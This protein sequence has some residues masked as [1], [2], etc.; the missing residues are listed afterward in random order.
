MRYALLP[1]S[2]AA[3][4]GEKEAP[5]TR[6][7]W[8]PDCNPMA[9]AG[10]CLLPLPSRHWMVEDP[11]SP[12]GLRFDYRDDTF[13]SPDGPLPI[14]IS[15]FNSL[16]G[17]PPTAPILLNLGRDVHINAL[18]G[19]DEAE[20][21][22]SADAPLAL[23]HLDTGARVPLLTEM[24][25]NNRDLAG[26]AYT[27]RHALILRPLAPMQPGGRYAVLVSDDLRDSENQPFSSPPV[28]AA[29]RDNVLTDDDT[30][31]GMRPRYE[32]I[33][34]A[35][36]A[37]GYPRERLLLAWDLQVAS[38][39]QV[40]GPIL[41]MRELTLASAE[42][43]IP[44]AITSVEYDV[45][46]DTH[47]R[48]RGTFHP[49]NFL[50]PESNL[51]LT[52][53]AASLQTDRPA[54][55]FTMLIPA[56]L[57]GPAPLVVFGHGIFGSGDSYLSGWIGQDVIAPLAR[58]S[59]AVIVATD[60]IGL[61]EADFDLIRDE[62]IPDL[63]RINLITD[64][65]AQSITNNV[66]LTS[67]ALDTLD[68]APALGYDQQQGG[69]LN[70]EV[71]Y[72]GVSLGGIQGSSYASLDPRV[73]RAVL[74]VPGGSWSSM[75]QRST[76]FTPIE[77][78]VD[79]LYPDPLS[80]LVFIN[81]LQSWFDRS[82]PANLTRLLYADPVHGA[83]PRA[84][85]LQEAIGDCQV[86]NL[87]TG[88]LARAARAAHLDT[89]Y[90]PIYDLP[91]VRAPATS[92]VLLTQFVLPDALDAYSPPDQNTIPD[93]DNGVH[94]DAILTEAALLQVTQLMQSGEIV[95]PCDGV[96]DPD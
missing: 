45:D 49:P 27:G 42:A 62:V 48:V 96:C 73:S 65:L 10:D 41:S 86:P 43:G 82:D 53:N 90:A 4:V 47:M 6:L 23:I 78:V 75:I 35:A 2:L 95:H 25:Q 55:P 88:I 72:Y 40:L 81:L 80:Q 59:Q 7:D 32:D 31:E 11:A 83:L 5:A 33:F 69:L 16:D 44:Y 84:L 28:F 92:G 70:G 14:Q 8:D 46:A 87:A 56:G 64:R 68:Q 52:E 66:A 13:Q 51:V 1:L 79:S 76:N 71:Y 93:G 36:E 34:A 21:S 63:S 3:C 39:E 38:E 17:A 57:T 94:S 50:D 19:L 91:T 37:A 89:T 54:Y 85:I 58:Q 18:W 77:V 9:M 20:A 15:R 61:S 22:M 29:L 30:I 67:L 26:G 12:T 60:W 24:D 74:A